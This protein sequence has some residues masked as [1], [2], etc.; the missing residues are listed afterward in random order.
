MGT[1]I[2]ACR[3]VRWSLL[4]AGL[5]FLAGTPAQAEVL[6]RWKFTAADSW[7][8]TM[9]MTMQQEMT[10]GG[11]AVK[12]VVDQTVD[13]TWAVSSVDKDGSAALSQTID[14]LRMD[15]KSW[16]GEQGQTIRFDSASKEKPTGLGA[17]LAPMVESLIGKAI[18]MRVD[19]R[20]DVSDFKVPEDMFAGMKKSPG[21]EQMGGIFTEDGLKQMTAQAMFK[22][23]EEKIAKGAT[24]TSLVEMPNPAFGKQKSET[25]YTYKGPEKVEGQPVETIALKVVTGFDTPEDSPAQLEIKEQKS[26]GQAFFDNAQGRLLRSE[27]SS[28]MKIEITAGGM[29][30]IQDVSVKTSLKRG[31]AKKAG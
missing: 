15:V 13:Y 7:T 11:M 12:T 27:N 29:T 17:M 30:F 20:G 3:L 8:Y 6:L 21:M 2:A 1:S 23:P 28:A 14:R 19:P 26:T 16:Q 5:A 22:F 9:T 25:T 18:T 10:I 31:P 24:W 4:L